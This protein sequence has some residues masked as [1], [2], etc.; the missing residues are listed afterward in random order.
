LTTRLLP[1]GDGQAEGHQVQ[2]RHQGVTAEQDAPA[3]PLQRN[4]HQSQPQRHGPSRRQ[5][6]RMA[7]KQTGGQQQ[8]QRQ[9]FLPGRDPRI[10]VVGQQPGRGDGRQR[11]GGDG[12][13]G[14]HKEKL[15]AEAASLVIQV[16]R[17]LLAGTRQ[18]LGGHRVG[19]AGT[20][21]EAAN[22]GVPGA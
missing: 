3:Y 1:K 15:A 7:H 8:R 21:L 4:A 18:I 12:Q 9:A 20:A 6:R 10:G 13:I 14:L 2:R 16:R 22:G 11:Q 19:C 5:S 17:G